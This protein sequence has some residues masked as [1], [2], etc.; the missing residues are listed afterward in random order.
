MSSAAVDQPFVFQ[1]DTA[2]SADPLV[3]Q[4]RRE[5][6]EIVR[7]VAAAVRSDRSEQE[8]LT[9]LVDRMLRAM[10]AEG[11]VVWR[12][13]ELTPAETST[14]SFEP[15]SR[16]GQLTDASIPKQST[17]THQRL[18]AEV[19]STGQPVVVPATPKASQPDT[20]ANP[21]HVPAA[22]AV[23]ES[24]PGQQADYLLEVFL[25]SSGAAAT[26]RGYLRFV[27]Q[28]ADLAGEYLRLEKIRRLQ[29]QERL[30]R[31][32]DQVI[33]SFHGLTDRVQL[34]AAIVDLAAEVFQFDRVGL[35]Y[36]NPPRVKLVAVSHVN[37][38]AFQSAAADQIRRAAQQPLD[39]G[40]CRWCEP[41]LTADGELEQA[42]DALHE[43]A[44]VAAGS[45]P[46][47]RLVA[48]VRRRTG[49]FQ[50]E[51]REQLTRLMRHAGLAL[52]HVCRLD[53]IPGG[54]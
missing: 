26:Q 33:E 49:P 9:F 25:D 23:L 42:D 54:R 16:I 47:I 10:A 8:F 43:V 5:I 12:R 29:R 36:V 13:A 45:E 28:M 39:R 51:Q 22:L 34:E 24:D 11:I 46:S 27:A 7:E 50:A 53:A 18:L 48:L 1:P 41:P 15:V 17:A 52:E 44:V 37:T 40:G 3:D 19:A 14:A 6:S 20:P 30:A 38:I 4:T 21:M 32:V 35:C 2:R 31:Q